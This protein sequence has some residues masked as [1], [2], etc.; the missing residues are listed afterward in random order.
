MP[1]SLFA[2]EFDLLSIIDPKPYQGPDWVN[3]GPEGKLYGMLGGDY[4]RY[5]KRTGQVLTIK[6]KG[7]V[8]QDVTKS[9]LEYNSNDPTLVAAK[10]T[11]E[12]SGLRP[13]DPSIQVPI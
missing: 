5:N 3:L 8:I 1:L 12:G 6:I 4:N 11:G 7:L 13:L 10:M 9:W 2:I